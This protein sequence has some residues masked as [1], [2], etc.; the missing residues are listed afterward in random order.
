MKL[1]SHRSANPRY[2]QLASTVLTGADIADLGGQSI[3]NLAKD[4]GTVLGISF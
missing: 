3:G 2:G 4:V 1:G